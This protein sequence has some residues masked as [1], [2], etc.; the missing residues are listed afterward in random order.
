MYST[1]GDRL[2]DEHD[3]QERTSVP[4]F[5]PARR[6]LVNSDMLSV[7][8]SIV[9]FFVGQS[10]GKTSAS[11]DPEVRISRSGFDL[12]NVDNEA[13]GF[14]RRMIENMLGQGERV[15]VL[16]TY[17][18]LYIPELP[19]LA[20]SS[21]KDV[22]ET[23]RTIIFKRNRMNSINPNVFGTIPGFE[24]RFYS[25]DQLAIEDNLIQQ[26]PSGLFLGDSFRDLSK[27][28]LRNNSMK[29]FFSSSVEAELENLRAL[30]L[31]ENLDLVLKLDS[32]SLSGIGVLD[33]R[34]INLKETTAELSKSNERNLKFES[35]QILKIGND[36][37][38]SFPE[39]LLKT[40]F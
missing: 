11:H 33:I 34:N 5:A 2:S 18:G 29:E 26:V 3:F 6:A 10:A 35:L 14:I 13:R 32:Q 40:D 16:L 38:K 17:E 27:I 21:T 30:D 36:F 20:F 15:Q 1:T 19:S 28:S 9:A 24:N 8:V 4:T 23:L 12:I 39:G 37:T 25:V 7:V 22:D 31:S